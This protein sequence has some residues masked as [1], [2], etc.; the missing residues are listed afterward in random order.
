[1]QKQNPE[2]NATHHPNPPRNPIPNPCHDPNSWTPNPHPNPYPNQERVQKLFNVA[3][4]DSNGAVDFGEFLLL[5]QKKKSR[6]GGAGAEADDS[7]SS[8]HVR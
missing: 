5:E 3:D 8:G 4:L 2:P 6:S 7:S 1:M